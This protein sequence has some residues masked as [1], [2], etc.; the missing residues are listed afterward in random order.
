MDGEW[1]VA[2]YRVV[3]Y[4]GKNVAEVWDFDTL[5]EALWFFRRRF[6]WHYAR[7]DFSNEVR[8]ESQV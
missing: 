6:K 4:N 5:Q 3:R 8:I 1:Y 2:P 7:G